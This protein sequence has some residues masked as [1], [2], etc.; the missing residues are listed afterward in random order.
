MI[1]EIACA[2][3]GTYFEWKKEESGLK[4]NIE[5]YSIRQTKIK[6]LD[7]WVTCDGIKPLIKNRINKIYDATNFPKKFKASL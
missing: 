4:L 2:D 5:N 7:F 1:L 6:Y 3:I